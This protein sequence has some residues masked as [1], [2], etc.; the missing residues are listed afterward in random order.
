[1]NKVIV[2]KKMPFKINRDIGEILELTFYNGITESLKQ[3]YFFGKTAIKDMIGEGYLKWVE[4]EKTL[5][6]EIENKLCQIPSIA[7]SR[8]ISLDLAQI[9]TDHFKSKFDEARTEQRGNDCKS[10][11]FI[12]KAMFGEDA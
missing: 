2:L 10:C 3:G 8:S 6:E 11:G 9:A 7:G 12:R 5:E 1:M 4:E